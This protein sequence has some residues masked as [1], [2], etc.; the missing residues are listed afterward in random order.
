MKST[1]KDLGKQ[2][3]NNHQDFESN[4]YLKYKIPLLKRLVMTSRARREYKEWLVQEWN[5]GWIEANADFILIENR[6][7]QE[8]LELQAQRIFDAE[9][10][11]DHKRLQFLLDNFL[12]RNGGYLD[13]QLLAI[14]KLDYGKH[15]TD[16]ATFKRWIDTAM[17]QNRKQANGSTK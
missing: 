12:K 14:A 11:M 5:E 17:E 10:F 2:A 16:V 15:E 13:L 8:E 7:H 9:C 6:I 4:P 1:P 3:R